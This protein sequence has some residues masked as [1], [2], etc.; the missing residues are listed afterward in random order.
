MVIFMVNDLFGG[1]NKNEP[2]D[3]EYLRSILH[4]DPETGMWRWLEKRRG[5]KENRSAGYV[6]KGDGRRRIRIDYE[7]YLAAPLA[8]LYMTGEW[9]RREVDH[10]N[11]IRD[12]DRW[13]NLRLAT[14]VQQSINKVMSAYNKSGVTGV[15]WAT[16]DQKWCATIAIKG[17]R[18]WLG[19]YIIFEDAVAARKKAE[20]KYY[21]EFAPVRGKYTGKDL[22]K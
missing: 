9:P 4:Y 1:T 15:F 20:I 18:I 13:Q 19:S 11:R 16:K 14:H 5:Q 8:W 12:D 6:N 21:G 17:E 3:A 22:F 2:F 7:A 10:I